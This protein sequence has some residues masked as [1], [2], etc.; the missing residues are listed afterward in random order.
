MLVTEA[1]VRRDG[2]K[3][4]FDPLNSFRAMWCYFNR[5]SRA[6]DLRL[7]RLRS[8]EI[9]ESMLTGE[10]LPARK[11]VESARAG[12]RARRSQ[13]SRVRWDTG[14][15]GRSRRSRLRDRRPN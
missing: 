9:D 10:S 7:V 6:A 2:R 12:N 11:H 15:P 13:E 1:T 8:L 14:N 3:Q 5:R 4:Q